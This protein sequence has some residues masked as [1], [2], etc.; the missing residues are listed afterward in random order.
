MRDG[1]QGREILS[2]GHLYLGLSENYRDHI[3]QN[4]I[5]ANSISTNNIATDKAGDDI[6][7]VNISAAS[8]RDV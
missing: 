2:L 1:L 3:A 5:A 8:A 6:A 7:D 4:H